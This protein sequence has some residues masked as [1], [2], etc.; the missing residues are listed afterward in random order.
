M[1]KLTAR[2]SEEGKDTLLILQGPNLNL[3]GERETEIYG[4]DTLDSLHLKLEEVGKNLGV[5]MDYFQSNHEGRI[6]DRI[7]QARLEPVA[8]IIIN[9]GAFTHTS[10]AIRDALLGVNIPFI[11]VHISNIHSRESFRQH[12]YLSDIASGVILGLGTGGYRLAM[13]AL[14]SMLVRAGV[15][16]G[17]DPLA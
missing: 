7:Q 1:E 10:V 4:T 16:N 11:E 3:L 5:R 13:E 2:N 14:V 9:P 8:G 12:S 15:L 6:V 17:Q